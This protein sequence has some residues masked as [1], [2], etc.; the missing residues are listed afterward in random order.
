ME[1]GICTLCGEYSEELTIIDDVDRVCPECLERDYFQCDDC[2]EYWD[3]T[4][5]EEFYIPS[6]EKIVC[7]HCADNYDPALFE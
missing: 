7:E 6:L 5:V 4:W 2:G 1:K 3:C